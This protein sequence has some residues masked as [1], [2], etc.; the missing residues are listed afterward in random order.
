LQT[1]P[2]EGAIITL[3]ADTGDRT[4]WFS[5]ASDGPGVD[6]SGRIRLALQADC[7]KPVR[8][9]DSGGPKLRTVA[10]QRF[11]QFCRYIQPIQDDFF[12]L[13]AHK[14]GLHLSAKRFDAPEDACRYLHR[15]S[16]RWLILRKR[17]HARMLPAPEDTDAFSS[18]VPVAR[19]YLFNDGGRLFGPFVHPGH[20]LDARHPSYAFHQWIGYHFSSG[21]YAVK[22]LERCHLADGKP[23][24]APRPVDHALHRMNEG[25][26]FVFEKY[27]GGAVQLVLV[28]PQ[29]DAARARVS[30]EPGCRLIAR[31]IYSEGMY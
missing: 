21:R 8:H 14:P 6:G 3:F 31:W 13:A 1:V 9:A 22:V 29:L 11:E 16:G 30:G 12:I 23:A 18:A 5:E 20:P 27:A 25:D 26:Y 7:V 4:G 19:S 28:T 10:I 24:V 2:R 17:G 15:R